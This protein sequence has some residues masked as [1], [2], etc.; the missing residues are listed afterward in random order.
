MDP[1]EQLVL[2]SEAKVSDGYSVQCHCSRDG[3]YALRK[4][5]PA[6]ALDDVSLKLS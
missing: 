6:Y 3:S 4:R 1:S 5:Q 2:C